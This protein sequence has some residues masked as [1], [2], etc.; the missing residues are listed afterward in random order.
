MEDR[1]KFIPRTFAGPANIGIKMDYWWCKEDFSAG[2]REVDSLGPHWSP[3]SYYD[4]DFHSP[5]V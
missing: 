1:V 3:E 5:F 2:G 4:P